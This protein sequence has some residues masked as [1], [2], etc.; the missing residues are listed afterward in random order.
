M[1][2]KRQPGPSLECRVREVADKRDSL[3]S[4]GWHA[5]ETTPDVSRAVPTLRSGRR[6]RRA[7]HPRRCG[8]Q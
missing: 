3:E 6:M 2:R 7:I 4:L 8:H 5:R 1:D